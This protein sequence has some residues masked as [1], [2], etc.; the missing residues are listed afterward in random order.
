MAAGYRLGNMLEAWID[1]RRS[2]SMMIHIVERELL[3]M[4]PTV[5]FENEVT[6]AVFPN[7]D[8]INGQIA[9]SCYMLQD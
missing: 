1:C 7:N 3:S 5:F 9:F 8:K 6:L 2:K 4:T